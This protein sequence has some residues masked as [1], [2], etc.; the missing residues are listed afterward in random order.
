MP[1]VRQKRL[2]MPLFIGFLGIN[3]AEAGLNSYNILRRP[4]ESGFWL[5][6]TALSDILMLIGMGL[7]I[8]G[9]YLKSREP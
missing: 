2:P 9:R 1:S 5:A 4:G 6:A 8:W 3:I 7:F